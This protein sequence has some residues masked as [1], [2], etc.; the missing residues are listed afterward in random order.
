MENGSI[1]KT[2][3][4][5]G[6][7]IKEKRKEAGLSQQE[8]ADKVGVARNT[9]TYWEKGRSKPAPQVVPK[10]CEVLGM[11]TGDI[12][13]MTDEPGCEEQEILG[14]YRKLSLSGRRVLTTLAQKL[15][16]E[17][18]L[19]LD[20]KLMEEYALFGMSSTKA[21]AGAGTE[22]SSL[23]DGYLF[24]RRTPA[25]AKANW[26]VEVSG[27]SMS[28]AYLDGDLVYVQETDSASPGD[29]VVVNTSDGL[30]I[31]RLT[32]EMGLASINPAYPYEGDGKSF[33]IAGKVIGKVSPY[34]RPKQAQIDA[35]VE[36]K[37]EEVREFL[38]RHQMNGY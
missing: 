10:L 27:H 20:T 9:I 22:Y 36:L 28:P 8:L 7:I 3:L 17:E 31:K 32:P 34:E 12:F 35:L 11:T 26:V 15:Y 4:S 29:V 1:T 21:A 13:G 19:A 5:L 30:V 24:L 25:N 33:K 14:L 18:S 37:A 23:L 2:G 6:N 38:E 16:E